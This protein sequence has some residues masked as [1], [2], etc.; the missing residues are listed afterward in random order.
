VRG[1]A[2]NGDG[3]GPGGR[4]GGAAD[5]IDYLN[6]NGG[7]IIFEIMNVALHRYSVTSNRCSGMNAASDRYIWR[8][9]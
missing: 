6:G 5:E 9:R 7:A 1:A 3:V 4:E 2:V 8:F